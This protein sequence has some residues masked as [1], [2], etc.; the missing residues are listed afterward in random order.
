MTKPFSSTISV[1]SGASSSTVRPPFSNNKISGRSLPRHKLPRV[2]STQVN[3]DLKKFQ[4]D[5]KTWHVMKGVVRDEMR[6]R[7]LSGR[8]DKR[9]VDE[10]TNALKKDFRYRWTEEKILD[11]VQE[12]QEEQ[13]KKRTKDE[14]AKGKQAT[15]LD[16]LKEAGLTN[17]EIEHLLTLKPSDEYVMTL[18]D[19][20]VGQKKLTR[21]QIMDIR[22]KYPWHSWKVEQI[23]KVL[24]PRIFGEFYHKDVGWY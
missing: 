10:L 24:K 19:Y 14:E 17:K 3:K 5:E 4:E 11:L 15:I 23:R 21:S 18:S 9:I 16:G 7:K 12:I 22:K 20:L 13:E 1:G 6:K 8:S 2:F